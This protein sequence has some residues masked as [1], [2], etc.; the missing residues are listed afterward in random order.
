MQMRG[1]RST[2]EERMDGREQDE[3]Q[4]EAEVM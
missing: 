4:K 2:R 3:A 1:C